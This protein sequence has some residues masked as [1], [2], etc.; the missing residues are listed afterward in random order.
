MRKGDLHHHQEQYQ[1]IPV[2]AGSECTAIGIYRHIM[3]GQRGMVLNSKRGESDYT[4]GENYLL[5]SG[6]ALEQLPR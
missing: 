4:L 6:E 5:E 2:L 1:N 3:T